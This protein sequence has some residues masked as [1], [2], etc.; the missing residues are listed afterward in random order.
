[1]D[2]LTRVRQIAADT[3]DIPLETISLQSSSDNI[4]AWDS[5]GHL[6]FILALE[7]ELGVRFTNL[8]EVLSIE[9]IIS[10]IE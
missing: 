10:R 5:L 2:Y 4:E 6:N 1:M 7:R 3:F 9:A 8:A